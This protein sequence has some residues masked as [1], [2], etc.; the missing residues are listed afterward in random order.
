MRLSIE[1]VPEQ[2]VAE[3][4]DTIELADDLGFAVCFA[5]DETY[6]KDMW[7][8]LAAAAGR[9]RQIHLSPGVTHVVL[10]DP[11]IIAH[12][13]ATLDEL[14]GGRAEAAFSLGNLAML[15]QYHV[16]WR[17]G[18]P[19]RRLREA[20]HVM[21]TML[22]EGRLD[23]EGEIFQYTGLFTAARPVQAHLPIKLGGM[24][25]P[26]S[27]EL[28]G[29]ISDG[30]YTACAF[31][32]CALQFVADHVRIGAERAGRDWRALDIGA[33]FTCAVSVDGK[34]AKEAARVKA[35]FYIPSMPRELIERHGIEFDRVLPI[36]EAFAG[37]DVARALELTTP[38]LGDAFA[39]AGTPEE[40]VERIERDVIPSG[41]NHIVFALTDPFLV[42]SWAGLTVDG[43]PDVNDQLRLIHD[44]VLPALA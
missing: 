9:T 19:L 40:I 24:R 37:G 30:V 35:A 8:I 38:D 44:H 27:F 18:S 17:A 36:N 34:A 14:S 4:I 5:V 3:L 1:L 6:H 42:E 43:L 23:F 22:D 16:D 33:S 15:E 12:Q 7:Q 25:G 11:T 13:L 28:A 39:L 21:R 26:K 29:E 41:F 31:S 10:K 20:H 2:P 32:P